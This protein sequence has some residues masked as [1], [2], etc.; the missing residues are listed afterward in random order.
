MGA[1]ITEGL[2]YFSYGNAV[3]TEGTFHVAEYRPHL[4]LGDFM[5]GLTSTFG[6]GTIYGFYARQ[7]YD[8]LYVQDN[9]KV[10]PRL[11]LNYGLRWEPYLS[12]TDSGGENESFVPFLVCR[13][14]PQQRILERSRRVVFSGRSAVYQR[15]LH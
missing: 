8:S 11:T 9:W 14:I 7:Y 3:G 12:F 6:Q 15:K 5:L 1:F 13:G 4:I 10:T 2:N